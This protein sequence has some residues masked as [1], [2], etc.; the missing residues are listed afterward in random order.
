VRTRG[1]VAGPCWDQE[2]V[3]LYTHSHISSW[4]GARAN[5]IFLPLIIS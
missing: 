1:K 2:N 5:F 3:D 4:R